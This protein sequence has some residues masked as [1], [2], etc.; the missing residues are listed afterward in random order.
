MWADWQA[1]GDDMRAA[2]QAYEAE[3]EKGPACPK[4]KTSG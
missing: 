1:V 3:R 4:T 2:L